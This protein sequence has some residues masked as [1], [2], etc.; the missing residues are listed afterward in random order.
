M[1]LTMTNTFVVINEIIK[2]KDFELKGKYNIN[3]DNKNTFNLKY[4]IKII[5]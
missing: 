4:K 5:N 3:V 2:E 1:H